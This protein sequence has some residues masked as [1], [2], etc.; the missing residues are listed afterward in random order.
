MKY[1][2]KIHQI[3]AIQESTK[4]F[5]IGKSISKV[6][7]YVFLSLIMLSFTFFSAKAQT[8]T[9][10]PSKVEIMKADSLIGQNQPFMQM[11]KLIGN[12][13]LRQGTTLLYCN[14][15]ILNET[16][17]ILEAYGKVKIIQA[18]T[19]TITGDTAYYFGN[20]RKAIINGH[21]KLDDR[22]IV[23]STNKL[24]Y[25]LNTSIAYY[26]TGGKIIDKKSTLTSKEGYYNTVTKL[27]DFKKDV[28]VLDKEG[29]L[30]ADSLRYSTL[31]KE[32]FFIA[33]T[34]VVNKKD[35]TYANPGS[36]Y[37]TVTK[38]SNLKGR[39]TVKTEDYT[40]TADTMIY[41]PPTEIGIAIGNIH[42]IS[43]K[44]KAILTG[45][46]GRYSKKT[47]VTRVFGHALLKNVL[48]NDTL[49]LTADTLVSIDNKETKTKKLYAYKRVLI[50]KSDFSGKC[51][52]LSYNVSDSTIYFYQKPVL[53]NLKNQSEADSINILLKNNKISVMNMK[54]KSFVIATDTLTN[55]NQIKGRKMVVRFTNDSKIERVNVEGNGE[56]IYYAV[57]EKNTLTGMNRV[58]C[59][60]MNMNF[61][62]NK[63]SRISFLAKPDGKFIPPK[64]LRE[65]DKELDG[66]RWRVTEIPTKE[67]ILARITLPK[68]VMPKAIVKDSVEVKKVEKKIINSPNNKIKKKSLPKL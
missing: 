41:D 16:T 45:D 48:E 9:G 44:D 25:D 29:S 11:K 19:V 40:M 50:Y 59:G 28:H 42:F 32:A 20:E 54:G 47:G 10:N 68:I 58:Q 61:A 23:L 35:T 2:T 14:L 39:S 15:A 7:S 63:I 8:P 66:F 53:W 67:S 18:D 34:L 62:K 30:T 27:F 17:N 4:A 43:K 6:L 5:E 52:S 38:I 65:E 57:D 26:N 33:P 13:G 22:T 56:S 24:D 55:Y 12:V 37:N 64:E 36:Q 31:S 3:N 1:S 60:K 51:D 46:R 21:V 49:F